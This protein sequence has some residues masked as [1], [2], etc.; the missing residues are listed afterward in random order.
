MDPKLHSFTRFIGSV[1]IFTLV[2]V[3]RR[4][5]AAEATAPIGVGLPV[6]APITDEAGAH[7]TSLWVT[8]VLEEDAKKEELVTFLVEAIVG[9]LGDVVPQAGGS[10]QTNFK[11]LK[12]I[13][14]DI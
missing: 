9:L 5:R 14:N 1:T 10:S 12:L 4:W 2:A 3:P 6:V 7:G 11:Q 13:Y 8:A